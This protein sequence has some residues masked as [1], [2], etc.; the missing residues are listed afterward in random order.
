MKN[1][2]KSQKSEAKKKNK[3]CQH[4]RQVRLISTQNDGCKQIKTK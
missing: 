1:K 2:K 3:R 4:S